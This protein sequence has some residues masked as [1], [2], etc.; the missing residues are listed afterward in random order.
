VEG[1][2]IWGDVRMRRTCWAT[3]LSNDTLDEKRCSNK[4]LPK[5]YCKHGKDVV[6]RDSTQMKAGTYRMVL[7]VGKS[8]PP[9][10]AKISEIDVMICQ[11]V[12]AY[13]VRFY[14]A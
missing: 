2:A 5:R 11:T 8:N 13:L 9:K 10:S 6:C 14:K 4:G 12:A 3:V 7:K 1:I